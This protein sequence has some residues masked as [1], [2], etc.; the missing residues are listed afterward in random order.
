MGK[1]LRFADPDGVRCAV[2][3]CQPHENALAGGRGDVFADVIGPNGKFAMAA[4]DQ[5]GVLDSRW[6]PEGGEGVHGGAAGAAGVEDVVYEDDSAGIEVVGK[7]ARLDG[8]EAA[9]QAQV[10]PVHG[11]VDGAG[12][13]ATLL[14]LLNVSGETAGDFDSSEGN[15]NE[16]DLVEVGVALNDF[17]SD[18]P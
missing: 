5:Y 18:A 10:I 4:V 14:K 13:D 2:C 16:G 7:L 15:P 6:S 17:V 8:D 12:F 11:D 3:G 1:P 9:A